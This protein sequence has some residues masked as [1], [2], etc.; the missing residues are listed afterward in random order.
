MI[1][2][3]PVDILKV[4]ITVSTGTANVHVSYHDVNTKALNYDKI[5]D[6]VGAA[7]Q[8]TSATT[9]G[10]IVTV[11][12]APP[13]NKT[14]RVIHTIFVSNTCSVTINVSVSVVTSGTPWA[15]YIHARSLPKD[16]T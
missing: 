4:T 11:C 8:N 9:T 6:L 12:A 14:R 2:L 5:N 13:D 15:W 1:F 16:S 3:T 10:G 7:N